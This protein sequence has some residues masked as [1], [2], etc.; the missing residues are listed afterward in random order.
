MSPYSNKPD[1]SAPLTQA[2]PTQNLQ[3]PDPKPLAPAQPTQDH[4]KADF[5]PVQEPSRLSKLV[6]NVFR[7]N[8][9]LLN[10]YILEKEQLV[11]E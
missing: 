9:I 7:K 11:V 10:I 1:N 6:L 2:I 3:F 4:L 5:E 8:L